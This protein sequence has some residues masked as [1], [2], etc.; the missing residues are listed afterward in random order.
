VEYLVCSKLNVLNQSNESSLVVRS[1]KEVIDLTL[2]TKR[3]RKLV[4]AMYLMIPL[5]R[6]RYMCFHL[7]NI[8]RVESIPRILR[9][10]IGINRKTIYDL[11]WRPF[12]VVYVL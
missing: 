7:G 6:D 3:G 12:P 8:A 5:Y 4:N 2:R 9:D 11:I 10:S 1:R